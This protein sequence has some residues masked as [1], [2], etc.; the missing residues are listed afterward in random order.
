M[1]IAGDVGGTKTALAVYEAGDDATPKTRKVYHSD[2]FDHLEDIVQAFIDE[3]GVTVEHAVFGMPGPVINGTVQVTNL[4][5][6]VNEVAMQNALGIESVRL[7]NDLEATAYALP[8]LPASDLHALKTI[9]DVPQA[10]KVIIAPGTGLGE[11]ML[12]YHNG[13]YIA[14]ASE[15]GHA[16]FAPRNLF[17]IELLRYLMGKFGHVSYERVCSGIGIPH[18]YDYLRQN[19]RIQEATRVDERLSQTDD[20]TPVIVQAALNKE[21]ELCAETL[22]TFVSILGSEASNM[23][24]NVMAKG[25]V[26]LGGGIPPKIIPALEDGTFMAAFTDKGRF[27]DML[28]QVPVYVILNEQAALF[29]AACYALG[30]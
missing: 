29:G 23:A 9:S 16:D 21:S 30:L 3:L 17:E 15:G 27:S 6:T 12:F 20:L 2:K 19:S 26:Y 14:S 13:H 18:I 8:F 4:P 1:L 22:N 28:S 25:G 11:G 10:N 7:L 24:L 5:W